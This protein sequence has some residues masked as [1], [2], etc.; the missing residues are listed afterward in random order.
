ME[1]TPAVNRGE[2]LACSQH[3]TCGKKANNHSR[4]GQQA[5]KED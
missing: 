4:T 5:I 1:F 3:P 2:S